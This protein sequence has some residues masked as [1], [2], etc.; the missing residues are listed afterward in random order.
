VK[1]IEYNGGLL[2]FRI[3]TD[4]VEEIADEGEDYDVAYYD[5]ND[6]E[7][8]TLA[9]SVLTLESETPVDENTPVELLETFGEVD[10]QDIECLPNGNAVAHYA[11]EVEENGEVLLTFHWLL[12]NTVPP[13]HGRLAA[14]SYTILADQAEEAPTAATI[15]MLD[16]EIRRA[17]FHAELGALEEVE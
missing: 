3:P 17:H 16:D 5:E 11:E 7:S 15:K 13:R 1:T 14:F 9:L 2:R 8:G 12:A 4:W 6:E 10:A